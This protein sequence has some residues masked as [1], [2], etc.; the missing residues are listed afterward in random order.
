M[1]MAIVDRLSRVAHLALI[2]GLVVSNT[3]P[4]CSV[5]ANSS[6]LFIEYC[7]ASGGDRGS[8]AEILNSDP[9]VLDWHMEKYEEFIKECL[10]LGDPGSCAEAVN[11]DPTIVD[12]PPVSGPNF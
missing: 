4:R 5:A 12:K 3:G 11:S 6:D 8:C 10:K 9:T 7:K 2:G 1:Q